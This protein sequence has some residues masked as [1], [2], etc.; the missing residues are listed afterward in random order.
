MRKVLLGCVLFI[1]VAANAQESLPSVKLPAE[2]DR[3]LRDY[4]QAWHAHDAAGL[5]N[6]FAEDGFVLAGRK[7]PVRGRE[8]I[9][10]AYAKSGGPL[11]L[12]ALQHAT[13][14]DVGYIIGAYGQDTS[15]DTGKFVLALKKV[16]DKWFIAADIDN[17]N[18]PPPP[19]PPVP[20]A[21]PMP[22]TPPSPT[23]T[24]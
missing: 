3:V 18:S 4:E 23:T 11:A 14:G 1:A 10:A 7:P 12:R 2:L 24:H 21:P 16:N 19:V 8:A 5:A 22:P 17:G 9:R 6:L 13:S 20:P 15:K